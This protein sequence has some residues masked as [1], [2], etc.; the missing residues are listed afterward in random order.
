MQAVLCSWLSGLRQLFL[1][2]LTAS[3]A[4]CVCSQLGGKKHVYGSL[5]GLHDSQFRPAGKRCAACGAPESGRLMAARAPAQG[6]A[7]DRRGRRGRRRPRGRRV[8][9][10]ARLDHGP[11]LGQRLQP[12]LVLAGARAGQHH[13]RAP[14]TWHGST[15]RSEV[16]HRLGV[17][18]RSRHLHIL[19]RGR[20]VSCEWL[21]G[22]PCT[23]VVGT[24]CASACCQR[25]G[26]GFRRLRCAVLGGPAA[27]A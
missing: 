17:L 27:A 23:Q 15:V 21:R 19:R 9:V 2:L 7:G 11:G 26:L 1:T 22:A 12:G 16:G 20:A 10:R 24:L 25:P 8:P 5:Y 6:R 18:A 3:Y 4:Q 14:P 13:V